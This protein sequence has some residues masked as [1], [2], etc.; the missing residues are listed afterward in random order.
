MFDSIE[1]IPQVEDPLVKALVARLLRIPAV[2]TSL[3]GSPQRQQECGLFI[4]FVGLDGD[5]LGTASAPPADLLAIVGAQCL[6]SLYHHSRVYRTLSEPASWLNL[7]EC[8]RRLLTLAVLIHTDH[9]LN[10]IARDTDLRSPLLFYDLLADLLDQ[11]RGTV[12]DAIQPDSL[13][14]TAELIAEN[15]RLPLGS[16]ETR[17]EPN[18]DLRD[19]CYAEG[20][21]PSTFLKD[22]YRQ[23]PPPQLARKDYRH[24]ECDVAVLHALLAHGG[25]TNILIHGR[26]GTGKTQLAAVLAKELARELVLIPEM[27]LGAR[28]LSPS[29]RL[30]RLSV[31]MRMLAD[32]DR[33]LVLFDEAE[34]VLEYQRNG[35]EPR[36]RTALSKSALIRTLESNTVPVVWVV[37]EVMALDPALQRRFDYILRL[38]SPGY[39]HRRELVQRLTHNLPVSDQW[40]ERLSSLRDV[41]PAVLQGAVRLGGV[42]KEQGLD[43]ESVLSRSIDQRLEAMDVRERL[44]RA[45]TD[46]A[47]PWQP[48][49]LNASENVTQLLETMHPD[50]EARFCLYGPPGTGKTAWAHI[51]AQKL[52]KPLLVRQA[53]DLQHPYVGMTERLI[54]EA[55]DQAEQ[56]EAVLLIDEADSF[57][58]ARSQANHSWEISHVNQFLTSME[59]FRGLLVT[60]TNFMDRIDS[61]A[62][63]RFDFRIRFDYLKGPAAVQ[64]FTGLCQKLQLTLPPYETLIEWFKPLNH[65][66]PGDFAALWRQCQVRQ[67]PKNAEGLLEQLVDSISYKSPP[68]GIGFM[69]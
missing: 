14:I 23:A 57:L 12:L 33:F 13:L 30:A 1:P 58:D 53:R 65:I 64:L 27:T 17:L 32:S 52:G 9:I 48:E 24:V 66:A 68:T 62:M 37:N 34:E 7:N 31:T 2:W 40:R 19:L 29:N 45:H 4:D 67:A 60:T 50:S 16:L 59:Q 18:E 69:A 56:D 49:A 47:L 46:R 5:N 42:A 61:A 8:Q 3:Q 38:D 25:G 36:H 35:R 15:I 54:G 63:R 20:S 21:D 26:P 28:V 41:P 44:G 43:V 55:F 6:E 11:P 10:L 22:F 39:R 51:L